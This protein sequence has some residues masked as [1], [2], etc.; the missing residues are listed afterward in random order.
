MTILLEFVSGAGPT[1][2]LVVI[3][4]FQILNLIVIDKQINSFLH[5]ELLTLTVSFN[6]IQTI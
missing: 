3:S 6:I 1:K 4:S 2:T 5:L